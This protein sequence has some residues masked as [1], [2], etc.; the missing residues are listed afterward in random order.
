MRSASPQ[1]LVLAS[2]SLRR[3]D[4]LRSAG[5]RFDVC[6]SDVAEEAYPGEAPAA[7]AE[8]MAMEKAR[9]VARQRRA[10]GDD[11]LVLGADTLVVIDGEILGKPVD[12]DA[13]R[14]MLQRMSGRTHT[15]IT[16]FCIIDAAGQELVDQVAT[17]VTFN[18]L[19][20]AEI[21]RYLDHAHWQDKAGAYAVQEH[22][23]YM[24]RCIHGSYTNVVGLPLCETVEALRQLGVEPA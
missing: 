2:S 5:L 19:Q 24:V 12:R 11:R 9:Q 1:S 20:E 8:R 3:R 16:A 18:E 7:F 15:V 23:A 21:E 17:E 10:A 22:A 13:A 4:L 6:V 14:A